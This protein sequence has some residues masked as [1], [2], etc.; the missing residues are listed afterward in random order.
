[1]RRSSVA[2]GED[3]DEEELSEEDPLNLSYGSGC[4]RASAVDIAKELSDEASALPTCC[5]PDNHD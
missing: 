4:Y 2:E 1:M 3:D 5:C